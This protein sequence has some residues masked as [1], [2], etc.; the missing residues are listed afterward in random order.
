MINYKNKINIIKKNAII[1]SKTLGVLSEYIKP[2]I[3]LLFLDKIA[4]EYIMDNNAYPAFLGLYNY[5][6]SICT[7]LNYEIA[8]GLPRD[9]YLNNGDIISIDC[10]VLK[11]KYYSDIAYTFPVGNISKTNKKLL[12][13]TKKSLYIGIKSCILGNNIGYIGY[14]INKYIKKKKLYI[15]K[16]LY[17]HGI[18]NKL[19]ENPIIPNY[20]NKYKGSIIKNG[21]TLAIE[22]MV[23][24]GTNKIRLSKDKWTYITKNKKNSAHFEHNIAIIN[25]KT[26]ILST[27]KYIKKK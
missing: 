5:P 3:N 26:K 11:N 23:N 18:G 13:Y 25:N 8:H 7:S 1:S 19:H 22:P 20:G 24:I 17:G 9:K 15:V 21:M 16:D 12:L 14:S 2:G 4:K 10:G 6:Y 27:F